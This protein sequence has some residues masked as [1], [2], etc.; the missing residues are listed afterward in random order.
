MLNWRAED[1][2]S[3]SPTTKL[4]SLGQ[5]PNFSESQS[6]SDPRTLPTSQGCNTKG[7]LGKHSALD[8]G[9]HRRE[10]QDPSPKAALTC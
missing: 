6:P 4:C 7:L 1:P 10:G 3:R 5:F 8:K 2:D 9:L